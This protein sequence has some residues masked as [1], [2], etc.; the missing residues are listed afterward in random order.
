VKFHEIAE[1]VVGQKSCVT[2]FPTA[3]PGEFATKGFA[4]TADRVEGLQIEDTGPKTKVRRRGTGVMLDLF[5]ASAF[6]AVRNAL[7]P[8]NREKLDALAAK[9]PVAAVRLAFRCVK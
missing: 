4:Y 7:N 5:S 1:G 2:F 6:V 8:A 3:T 9:S